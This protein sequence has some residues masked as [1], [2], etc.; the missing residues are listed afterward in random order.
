MKEYYS[1]RAKAEDI[2]DELTNDLLFY[3]NNAGLLADVNDIWNI[4]DDNL[5]VIR[6]V[7]TN[8]NISKEEKDVDDDLQKK[9]QRLREDFNHWYKNEYN[10]L[11]K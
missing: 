10:N 6:S 2:Y 3:G 4:F 9:S 8:Q 5:Y 11:V 7:A 1:Q